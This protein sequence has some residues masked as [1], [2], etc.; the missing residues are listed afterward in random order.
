MK[1]MPDVN[2]SNLMEQCG[3]RDQGW[4]TFLRKAG[5][6]VYVR[7]MDQLVKCSAATMSPT[8]REKRDIIE[9]IPWYK[10]SFVMTIFFKKF[11]PL[12]C[13]Y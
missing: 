3:K 12:V 13:N 9:G 4:A 5:Q 10:Q 2:W 11:L 7:C 8:K 6:K 1:G